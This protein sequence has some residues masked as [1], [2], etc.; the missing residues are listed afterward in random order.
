MTTRERIEEA[1]FLNLFQEVTNLDEF[2]E[3]LDEDELDY[4]ED[5]NENLKLFF[6]S[7]LNLRYLEP[8]I[9]VV[10]QTSL[11]RFQSVYLQYS[12]ERFKKFFRM[13]KSNFD[14]LVNIL[15]V[16]PIFHTNT[17][18]KQINVN[19][20][21]AVFLRRLAIKGDIFTI[22]SLFGISEGTVILYTNR[23]I[24]AI[25]E[26]KNNYIKWPIEQYRHEV[27]DGFQKIG[28]FPNVIG[29]IDGIHINLTNAPFKDPEVFFDRR[30]RYSI[31]CQAI[32]DYRGIFTNFLIGWPGS[33]HDARVYSNSDFYINRRSFIRDDDFVLGDSAYPISPFMITPF[34]VPQTPTQIQF[35]QLHSTHRIVVEHAFGRLKSRFT[36]LKELNV[37]NVKTAIRLTECAII[38]HNFLEL[39]GEIWDEETNVNDYNNND[40]NL[41]MECENDLVLKRAGEEKRNRLISLLR[42]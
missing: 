8:R 12:E 15:K 14:K 28:G 24:K 17:F 23:T 7:L 27:L 40:A 20:Q 21:I 19:F 37:K 6:V 22:S 31:Q 4:F 36:A 2:D 34:K 18:N 13:S 16:N 9:H 11:D 29:A 5:I 10:N 41:F 25:L 30:K 38:L 33:V 3:G 32:V 26:I 39:N 1:L 35:N 42:I